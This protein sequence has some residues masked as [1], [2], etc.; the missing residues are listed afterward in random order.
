MPQHALRCEYNERL[1]P[2]TQHLP[3]QEMKV[4]RGRGRL[5]DLHVVTSGKLQI[6]LDA[7]ARMLRALTFV[8]VGKQHHD[9]A[10]QSPLVFGGSDELIDYDL[11]AVSKVTELR[12]PKNERLGIVATVAI[13]KTEHASFRQ[14]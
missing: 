12:F 5:A 2:W 7:G 10:Q 14:Y 3:S 4:L 8:P 13:F 6:T 11:R 9:A 1:A